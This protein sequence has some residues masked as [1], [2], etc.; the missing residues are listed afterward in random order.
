M[1]K[2]L[3]SDILKHRTDTIEYRAI[4]QQLMK[5]AQS[6]K[7]E[8]RQLSI[9]DKTVVMLQNEGIK[10]EKITEF[11]YEKFKLSW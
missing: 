4:K 8:Y 6:G 5:V 1:A 2:K 11:N 10:V 9:S 3:L 7:N